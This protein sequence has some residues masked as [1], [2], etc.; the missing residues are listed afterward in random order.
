MLTDSSLGNAERYS[1]GGHLVLLCHDDP[2]RLGGRFS[3]LS[4]KSARSKRVASSILSAECL[5]MN[6]GIEDAVFIQTWLHE[7]IHPT[8][9]AAELIDVDPALLLPID[10]AMDCQDLYEVLIKPT[11]PVPTNKALTLHLA[12]LR[13]YK[14][15]GHVRAWVWVDTNDQLANVLTKLNADGTLP[16][17]ELSTALRTNHYEPTRPF[18]WQGLTVTTT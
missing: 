10:G 1:Q 3:L 15:R 18:K 13:E 16:M 4:F 17:D 5:A 2:K 6:Q 7:L 11:A 12:A 14:Q 8:M 9:R